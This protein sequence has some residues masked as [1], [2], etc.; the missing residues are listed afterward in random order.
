VID[1]YF[2]I[3]FKNR[4]KKYGLNATEAMVLLALYEKGGS[5]Q[6]DVFDDI[7]GHKLTKSQEQIIT[8]L[9]YDKAAMTRIMQSLEGKDY[10]TRMVNPV[11]SR[12]YLFTATEKAD[13]FKP[14]LIDILRDW[15]NLLLEGIGNLDM[16]GASINQMAENARQIFKGED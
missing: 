10:V 12:S 7:H 3:Y 11:D 14:E 1:K 4:L 6:E 16:V 13:A 15:N 5:L 9:Q 2:R 8:D